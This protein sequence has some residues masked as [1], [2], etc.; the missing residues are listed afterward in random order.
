MLFIF[1]VSY[2]FSI[3]HLEGF[4]FRAQEQNTGYVPLPSRELSRLN[5]SGKMLLET[6]NS[7]SFERIYSQDSNTVIFESEKGRDLKSVLLDILADSAKNVS[8]EQYAVAADLLGVYNLSRVGT[9]EY[10]ILTPYNSFLYVFETFMPASPQSVTY[11]PSAEFSVQSS[12]SIKGSLVQSFRYDGYT[13]EKRKNCYW[14]EYGEYCYDYDAVVVKYTVVYS[15]G[16]TTIYIPQSREFWFYSWH[17]DYCHSDSYTRNELGYLQIA[18]YHCK[19]SSG[20]EPKITVQFYSSPGSLSGEIKKYSINLDG[21]HGENRAVFHAK[22]DY[23]VVFDDK[24]RYVYFS[25][26]YRYEIKKTGQKWS[27]RIPFEIFSGLPK[28]DVWCSFWLE[29]QLNLTLKDVEQNVET[30]KINRSYFMGSSF[31]YARLVIG[32]YGS[33][34]EEKMNVYP[35]KVPDWVNR[36]FR[37]D[38]I[39][40]RSDEDLMLAIYAETARRAARVLLEKDLETIEKINAWERF[41]GRENRDFATSLMEYFYLVQIPL[42]VKVNSNAKYPKLQAFFLQEGNE[43]TISSL[44]TFFENTSMVSISVADVPFKNSKVRTNL[45]FVLTRSSTFSLDGLET[46]CGKLTV[47]ELAYYRQPGLHE[48][49]PVSFTS[50]IKLYRGY[51]VTGI[52]FKKEEK[53][54]YLNWFQ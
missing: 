25:V 45:V 26:D 18:V 43:S 2:L 51:T 27:S 52:E 33:W 5:V 29:D 41:F 3:L 15:L 16:S 6:L 24:E 34:V 21:Y 31:Y 23:R 1:A 39:D 9:I 35:E 49:L 10:P 8:P 17:E 20:S 47:A 22:C 32:Q 53:L 42:D 13:V 38:A 11:P 37:Y 7:W 28:T 46:N 44:Y 36:E 50:P 14:D 54:C 48:V 4:G 30:V 12:G 19:S 40:N